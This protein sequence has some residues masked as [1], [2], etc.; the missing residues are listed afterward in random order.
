MS[1]ALVE[2]PSG[3]GGY[4]D[5]QERYQTTKRDVAVLANTFADERGIEGQTRLM[6]TARPAIEVPQELA[7]A[8]VPDLVVVWSELVLAQDFR[9]YPFTT[10][11]PP[12][13]DELLN[14]LRRN[15]R[16]SINAELRDAQANFGQLANTVDAQRHLIL[17]ANA[18]MAHQIQLVNRRAQGYFQAQQ[19]HLDN[20][21]ARISSA[22]AA[23]RT[24]LMSIPRWDRAQQEAIRN[25][26]Y[27]LRAA[28]QTKVEGKKGA[29]G[30]TSGI[31][32]TTLE[33][34][35]QSKTAAGRKRSGAVT[36][37]GQPDRDWTLASE[38]QANSPGRGGEQTQRRFIIPANAQSSF[39]ASWI[40]RVL[41]QQVSES[42]TDSLDSR[43]G[44]ERV[45][46]E[47]QRT[48]A[49]EITE[50]FDMEDRPNTA[51][52]N[53][54]T[55]GSQGSVRYGAGARKLGPAPPRNVRGPGRGTGRGTT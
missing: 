11:E 13:W 43:Q 15:I 51:I 35:K 25:K 20:R 3:L 52:P 29:I 18:H 30:K 33:Q 55:S 50:T 16:N 8:L 42:E 54:T 22:L 19:S 1:V 39:A 21:E 49:D 45:S 24:P 48:A 32:P 9:S 36:G 7:R 27:K 41:D 44:E 10:D 26:Q 2:R 34:A 12:N 47:E 38:S 31:V 5:N 46:P 37:P 17:Q 53:P 23:M 28:P 6:I 4:L 14:I 40:Q